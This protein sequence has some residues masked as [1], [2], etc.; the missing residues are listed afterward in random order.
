MWDHRN[1]RQHTATGYRHQYVRGG[2]PVSS[3]RPDPGGRSR[4]YG[5]SRDAGRQVAP[6]QQHQ[7]R[8]ED[9]QLQDQRGQRESQRVA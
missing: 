5:Q 9:Q 1:R 6:Q 8:T 2:D 7:H 3:R 4:R